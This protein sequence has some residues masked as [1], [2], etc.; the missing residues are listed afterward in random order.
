M[1]KPGDKVRFL[2]D[3]GGGTVTKI[4]NTKMAQVENEDGFEIPVL[5]SELVV[6]E[7]GSENYSSEKKESEPLPA[8]K[9]S[10]QEPVI[11]PGKDSADFYLAFI[12]VNQINPV[13]GEIETWLVNDSNYSLLFNYS[14]YRKNYYKNLK[15]GHL[16][17]NSKVMLGLINRFDLPE[18]PEFCFQ[19]IYFSDESKVLYPPVVKKI[20]VNPVKF[21]KEKT[22][23]S[24]LFFDRNAYLLAISDDNLKVE[25]DKLTEEGLREVIALKEQERNDPSDKPPRKPE[26]EFMEV[27]LHISELIDN[28]S[29]LTNYEILQIQMERFRSELDNAIKNRVK[30]IVFIHG[31]GQ[32]TLKTELMKELNTR[33]RKYYFQDASFKEYG[34]GATMVI[35]RR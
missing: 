3:V 2:N 33:Y 16:G 9:A 34:Y 27:D 8:E 1:V 19:I 11:I 15:T 23:D 7:G 32:G 14:H 5:I 30:R 29:G 20:K 13:D 21:Y 10:E 18:I 17:S 6:T 4:L 24:N 25:L 31:V 22:F 12:P 28:T 35:L 26:R